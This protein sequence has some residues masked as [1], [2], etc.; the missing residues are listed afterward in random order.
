MA[1]TIL[2]SDALRLGKKI[3]EKKEI[4]IL[5]SWIFTFMKPSCSE[6]EKEFQYF[7]FCILHE[8][9]HAVLEHRPPDELFSQENEDHEGE[10]DKCALEWFNNY[11]LENSDKGYKAIMIEEIR[12]TQNEY[13]EKLELILI[14]NPQ[15]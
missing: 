4:I 7:I 14:D 12:E 5:S 9:A 8:V 10:A 15:S 6:D 13:Q 2:S 1:I 11:V 3:R